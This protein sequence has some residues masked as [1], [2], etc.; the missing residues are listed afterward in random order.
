MAEIADKL[1]VKSTV[2]NETRSEL[3]HWVYFVKPYGTK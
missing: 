1:E 2:S 3:I